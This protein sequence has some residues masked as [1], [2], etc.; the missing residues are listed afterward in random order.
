MGVHT[1]RHISFASLKTVGSRFH[2]FSE[3]IGMAKKVDWYY[4]RNG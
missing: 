3:L 4:H 2:I 1:G